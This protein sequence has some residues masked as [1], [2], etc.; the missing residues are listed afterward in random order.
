MRNER[1]ESFKRRNL[2]ACQLKQLGILEEIDRIC[3]RH[4]IC[5]WL[6]GGTLL[7]AVRHGGFIPWDDDID[8]AMRLEDMGRFVELARRELPDGLFVQTRLTDP[9][10]EAPITKVRD[11]DSFCVEAGDNFA[12]GYQKGLYVDIFPF[13]DYPTVPPSFVK[14]VALGISKSYSILHK[15]HH[16]SLRAMAELVW[17]GGMYC[18]D[19]VLWAA[20]DALCRH[21][22]YIGNITI[23]NG[24]GIMH[25]KDSVFPTVAI[26]FE[27]KPFSAPANPDAYLRDLY[28]DYMAL[29]PEDKRRSHAVFMLPHL[30]DDA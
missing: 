9:E 18:I 11:M 15:A 24:Y 26:D 20:A 16:Y 27:G 14:R 25:R 6:D 17:F 30:E 4:S 8:I 5:Y 2:R 28:H 23:N 19:S 12:A 10:V 3:R 7:G 21:G 13:V 1:L 29:P 22:T